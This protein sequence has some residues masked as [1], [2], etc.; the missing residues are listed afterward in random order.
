MYGV[1]EN[2]LRNGTGEL[3]KKESETGTVPGSKSS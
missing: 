3:F 1:N 2:R